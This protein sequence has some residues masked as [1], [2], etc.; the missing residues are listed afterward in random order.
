MRQQQHDLKWTILSVFILGER[1]NKKLVL[2]PN[3]CSSRVQVQYG[4]IG[5][6]IT[7][8]PNQVDE[9]VKYSVVVV[10]N[11]RVVASPKNCLAALQL[12]FETDQVQ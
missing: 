9:G 6:P 10:V 8:V 5:R 2:L 12:F 7:V 3:G 11:L 1:F 4:R